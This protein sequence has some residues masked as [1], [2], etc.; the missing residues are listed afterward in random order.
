MYWTLSGLMYMYDVLSR[1]IADTMQFCYKHGMIR[2]GVC[3][4]LAL[5]SNNAMY[6][7]TVFYSDTCNTWPQIL[8][9]VIWKILWTDPCHM[10]NA[11][12]RMCPAPMTRP[13]IIPGHRWQLP[14]YPTIRTCWCCCSNYSDDSLKEAM[15][16][17][18]ELFIAI[19]TVHGFKH[20]WC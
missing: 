20:S 10:V 17:D 3:K 6:I 4:R 14:I 8:S 19:S 2:E 9:V 16:A 18:F 12:I 15:L 1:G 13:L 5:L 7:D 11:A